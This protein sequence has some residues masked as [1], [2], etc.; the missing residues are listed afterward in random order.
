MQIAEN[1]STTSSALHEVL[2]SKVSILLL[3]V[4][5]TIVAEFFFVQ[6]RTVVFFLSALTMIPLAHFLSESTEHLAVHTG[7]TIG[8]LLNVTFGNASEL[9]IG[10]FALRQGLDGVVKASITGSILG[11][12]LLALG[13]SIIAAGGE[14]E[15]TQVQRPGGG[16]ARSM[17]ASLLAD[18]PAEH[19]R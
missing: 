9:L 11:N 3:L 10:F 8:G 17:R 4:P 6:H 15:N 19:Q 12:L 14:E 18:S 2:H 13:V 7:P 16:R 1:P 5:L